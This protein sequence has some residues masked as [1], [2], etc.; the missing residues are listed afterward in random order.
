MGWFSYAQTWYCFNLDSWGDIRPRNFYTS[1]TSE[2]CHVFD[3]FDGKF[4]TPYSYMT[5]VPIIIQCQSL[6][7]LV[8]TIGK[9]LTLS[10]RGEGCDLN[11]Q[12]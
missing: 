11:G 3:K 9:Y 2:E 8:N 6:S 1:R 12:G 10:V 7:L 5:G 4:V